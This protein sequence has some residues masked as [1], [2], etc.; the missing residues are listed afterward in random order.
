MYER[1]LETFNEDKKKSNELR[2]SEAFTSRSQ[3]IAPTVSPT[4]SRQTLLQTLGN[5]KLGKINE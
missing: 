2:R 1:F 3:V 4:N 5:S